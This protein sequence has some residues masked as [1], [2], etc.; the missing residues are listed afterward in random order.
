MK[1]TRSQ[2]RKL[3]NEAITD[4][5]KGALGQIPYGPPGYELKS[6]MTPEEIEKFD[7]RIRDAAQ[8]DSIA[9]A[10]GHEGEAYTDEEYEFK[11]KMSAQDP[12]SEVYNFMKQWFKDSLD[13]LESRISIYSEGQIMYG[14]EVAHHELETIKNQNANPSPIDTLDS[15]FKTIFNLN[16]KKEKADGYSSI[17]IGF[18]IRVLREIM[19]SL[20]KTALDK[21]YI[22]DEFRAQKY[23]GDT[24][25]E[26]YD[27]D[28][29]QRRFEAGFE[30]P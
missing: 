14:L 23:L 26:L 17:V 11:L 15:L 8:K 18:A 5:S 2:L 13:R 24:G 1:I 7:T 19:Q 10:L 3:I 22:A 21:D 25:R 27:P 6:N 20:A 28:A 9:S 16:S 12:E 30:S 29:R 4:M